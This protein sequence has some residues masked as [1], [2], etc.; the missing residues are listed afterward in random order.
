ME[1]ANLPFSYSW[2]AIGNEKAITFLDQSI[3][4]DRLAQTYVFI[5]PEELGKSTVALAFAKNLQGEMEGFNSD[6]HILNREAD[7]KNISI[8]QV[9]D[10]IKILNLSS[11]SGS[12]K[13]GLIKEADLLSEEAKSALLKTLEEP[14]EK[15]IIILLVSNEENLPA[16]ILSRSQKIYFNPVSASVIYD[17]L[18]DNYKAGRSQAKDLSALALGRPLRAISYLENPESYQAYLESARQVLKV[19]CSLPGDRIALLDEMFNDRTYSRAAVSSALEIVAIFEGLLRDML[20]ISLD[21]ADL[22]QHLALSSE[23]TEAF[24]ALG[25]EGD[26]RIQFFLERLKLISQAREYM[27]ANVNPRLV[28]EQLFF[29]L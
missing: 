22:I 21:K 16:T 24:S 13:I 3:K 26:D 29:N 17:Y 19:I 7:K 15:V 23:F 27:Q 12:Y 14:K 25:L 6:L 2:P 20:L 10:F 8:A 4:S 9:R 1:D 5:G 28:L 18:I 11:F